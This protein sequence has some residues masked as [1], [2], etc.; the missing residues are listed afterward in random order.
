MDTDC[1]P[2]IPSPIEARAPEGRK[3]ISY[4]FLWTS[5]SIRRRTGLIWL[6]SGALLILIILVRLVG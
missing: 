6:A 2:I 1:T 3:A 4:Q 5:L